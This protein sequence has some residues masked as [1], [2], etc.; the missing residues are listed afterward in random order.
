MSKIEKK[1]VYNQ[2]LYSVIRNS[3]FYFYFLRL[4]F[5]FFKSLRQQAQKVGH[6]CHSKHSQYLLNQI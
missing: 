2:C 4:D 1:Y 3:N 5:V 6:F